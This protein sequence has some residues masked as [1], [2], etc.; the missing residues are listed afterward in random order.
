METIGIISYFSI[1]ESSTAIDFTVRIDIV[2]W[3]GTQRWYS[4]FSCFEAM[5]EGHVHRIHP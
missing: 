5:F 3:Q 4:E 1:V 2:S